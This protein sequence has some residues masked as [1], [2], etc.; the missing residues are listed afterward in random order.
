[1]G[2]E[3][4]RKNR[5]AQAAPGAGGGRGARGAGAAA[6]GRRSEPAAATPAGRPS[7]AADVE[8]DSEALPAWRDLWRE[9]R[10]PLLAL[11][12]VSFAY[13]LA[14]L[15][16]LMGTPYAEV[17][18]IDSDAY[19][20]WATEI[21]NGSWIPTSG[22][23]QS[24][25]YAWY[26]AALQEVFGATTWPPRIGQIL[27]GSLSAPLLYAIGTRLYGRRVGILAGAMLA[28]YGPLILEEVTLSKTSLL[29]VAILGAFALHLRY[30]PRA[31][32]GGLAAAGFLFGIGVAG[33]AQWILG[34]V[35]LAVWTFFS[36]RFASRGRRGAAA[37]AFF[38]AGLAPVVPIAAWNTSQFG[39]LVLTSGGAGLNFYTGNNER[40]SGL[41]ASPVGL[42]DVPRFE[43][44]DSRR[45]AEKATGRSLREGEV[46][47]YWVRRTLEV[48]ASD[49]AAWIARLGQKVAVLWNGYEVPDNYHYA[50]MRRYFVP[51]LAVAISFSLLGPLALV[52]LFQPFWRRRQLTSLYVVT[53]GA[54]LPS[55]VFYVRSRYRL[56]AVPF[57]AVF[58]AWAVDRLVDAVRARR[59]QEM[60]ARGGALAVAL[61]LVDRTHCEAPHHGMP[62][63]CLAG[64]TWF[65]TEW[66][67]LGEWYEDRGDFERSLAL[68][69]RAEEC[70]S[71]RNAGAIQFA[72][73][74]VASRSAAALADRGD[75][76]AAVARVDTAEAALRKS[77]AQRYRVADA[78]NN[79]VYALAMV[80]L[81]DR[82]RAVA[83]D[84]VR[85]RALDRARLANIASALERNGRCTGAA[86]V[87]GTVDAEAADRI[88]ARCA[89][90]GTTGG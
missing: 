79:I 10:V 49:P 7:P 26:L 52:G 12:A 87:L 9:H 24:P 19:L 68:R 18:N 80:R 64:D 39:G 88:A 50:F 78:Y 82:A 28:F 83:A 20:A 53:A 71:P 6:A 17:G 48:I 66:L 22:Y 57:L 61:L 58:A 38:A 69:T 76:K 1:V 67:K 8:A 74:T 25:V 62:A 73:G 81:D 2:R 40:A 72:I 33:V 46:S 89:G 43:E 4:R 13:R 59:T 54:L 70:E 35:A 32:V 11:F 47:R 37:A 56:P 29:V 55:L 60:V 21:A 44:A 85:Q 23:Y 36:P 86:K 34:L 15:L 84:G 45:L 30:A 14:V 42:R 41:P 63:V 77:I 31:L 3:S 27:L 5:A 51:L 16:Q 90:G 65:D 75:T